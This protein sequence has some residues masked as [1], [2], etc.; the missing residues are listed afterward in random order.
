MRK[1]KCISPDPESCRVQVQSGQKA[2][3]CHGDSV[4]SLKNCRFPWKQLSAFRRVNN[5]MAFVTQTDRR[6]KTVG[7]Y[8]IGCLIVWV[9]FES[10]FFDWSAHQKII[11][12]GFVTLSM[13]VPW[14]TLKQVTIPSFNIFTK[15]LFLLAQMSSNNLRYLQRDPI[16]N[17]GGLYGTPSK[18]ARALK[19]RLLEEWTKS[20]FRLC[21]S[22][23]SIM[24]YFSVLP[25][26][27]KAMT[28]R[29]K[30]EGLIPTE[31][32]LTRNSHTRHS[33]HE[34]NHCDKSPSAV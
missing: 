11:L 10:R 28:L 26:F 27:L 22:S 12:R 8:I 24:S 6:N 30:I 29:L 21:T 1:W 9:D 2:R 20:G 23:S 5:D 34:Q 32:L 25:T 7:Y 4:C 31:I 3:R 15:S 14:C 16:L 13:N 33:Y 17:W 19:P 18:F